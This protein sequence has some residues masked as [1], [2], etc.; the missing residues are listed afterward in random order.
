MR[1]MNFDQWM[2]WYESLEEGEDIPKDCQEP[3][4]FEEKEDR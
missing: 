4:Y 3:T 2:S 1:Y